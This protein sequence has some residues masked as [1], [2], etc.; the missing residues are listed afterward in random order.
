MRILTMAPLMGSDPAMERELVADENV[1]STA[2]R[3][4]YHCGKLF[5]RKDDQCTHG[6]SP[7][8]MT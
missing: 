5:L 6:P 7:S 3:K 2:G 4:R 8:S 1:G